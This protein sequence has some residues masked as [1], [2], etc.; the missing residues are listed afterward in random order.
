MVIKYL[1]LILVQSFVAF[2]LPFTSR[3][4][5]K[6]EYL[7]TSLPG[8]YLNIR[9]D[10][11]PLMFAGQLELYPENQTHYFFWKYQDTNQI[12][13]AKKRTIFWLNGGPG[14]S[15]MDGALMEAGP[16]RIN[17]EGEVIYNEG[18]WHKSGDMVFVD[19]PAGT[20]FSYSDDYDH[21]LDQ[22]TVEFVRFMEKFLSYS[23]RMHRMKSI[24]R[25]RVMLVSTSHISPMEYYVVIRT[26]VRAKNRLTLKG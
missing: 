8:L 24:L 25:V 26:C 23:L 15:S 13:E 14:C 4:D 22:I 6:A 7:V 16:F 9:T 5:P 20:G 1:L 3:S 2:A 11:R 18:S 19:Q 10:E 21:D 17:K 12:P